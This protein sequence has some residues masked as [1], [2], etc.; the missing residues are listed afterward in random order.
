M[1]PGR[2]AQLEGGGLRGP[3]GW[4]G[5]HPSKDITLTTTSRAAASTGDTSDTLWH[6]KLWAAPPTPPTVEL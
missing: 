3:G 5:G 2:G 4:L 1:I 6:P